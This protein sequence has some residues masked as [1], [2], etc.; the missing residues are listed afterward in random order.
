MSKKK[1]KNTKVKESHKLLNT[2]IILFLVI[3]CLFLYARY[4]GVT[5]VNVKEYRIASKEIPT[6]FSGVKI[7][8]LSDIHYGSTTYDK[9]MKVIVKKINELKPDLIFFTGDLL[10]SNMKFDNDDINKLSNYL[11]DIDSTL[12]KYRVL[13]NEDIN[14]K[15]YKEIMDKTDFILLDNS[16][17]LIYNEGLTP[18][19]LGGTSTSL[20]STI[21]LNAT[22]KYYKDNKKEKT[23][24][25]TY[26]IILTHEG[27][28]AEEIMKYDNKVNL[29]LAGHSHNGQIVIPYYGG[30]FIPEG[31][32]KYGA[33]HYSINNTEIYISS[34]IGTTILRYRLF[35]KPSFNLYRLKSL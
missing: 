33:P 13:G 16:Y 35:N 34:G 30:I 9:D 21:D 20:K 29:I 2:F 6:N 17:E 5:G 11:N 12:G 31:S 32:K 26:K 3:V 1:K 19:Y 8:H 18:I 7:I 23:Y 14:N 24:T 27:D 4:L 15:Y 25:P 28:N 22:F 10:D